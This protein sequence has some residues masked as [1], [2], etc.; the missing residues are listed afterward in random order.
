MLAPWANTIAVCALG[1][2]LGAVMTLA[3]LFIPNVFE[4]TMQK[5]REDEGIFR[6]GAIKREELRYLM[7][8]PEARAWRIATASQLG[9]VVVLIGTIW[10]SPVE[11]GWWELLG[12][13]VISS[14]LVQSAFRRARAG[15]LH[16]ARRPPF[17]PFAEV[18]LPEVET[19][20]RSRRNV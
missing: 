2:G 16:P 8:D 10:L 12:S 7:R 15:K 14:A 20:A 9:L 5:R 4:E 11:L 1:L 19:S 3:G 18:E 6:G 17:G 13:M